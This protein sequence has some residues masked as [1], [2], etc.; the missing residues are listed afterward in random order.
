MTCYHKS[1]YS[2][3]T[4]QENIK[5][6][7]SY[8]C[9]SSVEISDNNEKFNDEDISDGNFG[10]AKVGKLMKDRSSFGKHFIQINQQCEFNINKNM[11]PWPT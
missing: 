2:S 1:R 7:Q 6:L 5:I 9:G 10:D 11:Q 8:I 4:V 3:K